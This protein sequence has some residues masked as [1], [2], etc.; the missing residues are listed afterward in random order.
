MFS[1]L[2]RMCSRNIKSKENEKRELCPNCGT[3]KYFNFSM[4]EYRNNFK[5]TL[6]HHDI[7]K[8][9][10]LFRCSKCY[11]YWF[12]SDNNTVMEYVSENHIDTLRKW[13]KRNLIADKYIFEKLM[14]IGDTPPDIYGNF[15]EFVRIPCKC[16][17]NGGQ[18][19]DFCIVSF[20]KTPPNYHQLAEGNIL[21][22][23]EVADVQESE[24][25]LSV[26]VRS[27][28]SLAK[29]IR[30]CFSPTLVCAPDEKKFI[31]NGITNFFDGYGYKGKDITL[32][33]DDIQF[34]EKE[35]IY[36]D[37]NT[38]RQITWVIADLIDR[39]TYKVT[40]DNVEYQAIVICFDYWDYALYDLGG[41]LI[42]DVVHD[43]I[44]TYK[45]TFI[46][47]DSETE[48][49]R[50]LGLYYI[51]QLIKEIQKSGRICN[52][53]NIRERFKSDLLGI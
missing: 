25:A 48:S 29:E 49:F 20:Q 17:M 24:Y 51:T 16:V 50:Y 22:I 6:E 37:K 15:K 1:K 19:I 12:I 34:S 10:R 47:N 4:Q 9:G 31:L 40:Y 11:G 32:P 44:A 41:V 2:I 27:K 5:N 13:N 3:T 28:T 30:M 36:Y 39:R 45:S 52:E 26:K 43:G 35:C 33:E 21:F 38:N 14:S 53:R 46:L 18:E 23:D 42:L 7:C 8:Y